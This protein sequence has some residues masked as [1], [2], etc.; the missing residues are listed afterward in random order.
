MRYRLLQHHVLAT[1]QALCSG[2]QGSEFGELLADGIPALVLGIFVVCVLLVGC[3]AG[4]R[5]GC[6][7][8]GCLAGGVC[9]G[10][11]GGGGLRLGW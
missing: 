6:S 10:A 2:N 11:G 7:R 8:F 9:G 3:E 1:L 4:F 5:G